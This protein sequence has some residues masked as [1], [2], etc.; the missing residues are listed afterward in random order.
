MDLQKLVFNEKECFVLKID[1]ITE[2][3]DLEKQRTKQKITNLHQV[4]VSTKM[5]TPLKNITVVSRDLHLHF[6]STNKFLSKQLKLVNVSSSLLCL[7]VSRQLD[8][9]TI[10]QHQF[11]IQLESAEI[12]SF[13]KES[14]S[15]L[16]SQAKFSGILIKINTSFQKRLL[17]F[18]KLRLSSVL[19]TILQH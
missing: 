17:R 15:L 4:E 11:T 3:R 7:S 14:V 13:V 10:A 5:L 16:D 18:D 19:I 8:Q 12:C 6:K 2:T 9:N 1:D